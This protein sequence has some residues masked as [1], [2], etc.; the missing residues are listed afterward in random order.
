MTRDADYKPG[1]RVRFTSEALGTL[2]A[3]YTKFTE[4]VVGNGDEGEV[5]T[6]PGQMPDGWIAVKPDDYPN[7]YVPV[8][9]SMIE[10]VTR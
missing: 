4:H 9:P 2:E 6:Y 5:M 8:H 10:P 3:G 7:E 1:D